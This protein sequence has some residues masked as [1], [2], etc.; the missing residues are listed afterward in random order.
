MR[1]YD[2]DVRLTQ[3]Q[4]DSDVKHFLDLVRE[5][6]FAGFALESSRPLG[7]RF[8]EKDLNIIQRVTLTPRSATR[9]RSL[10]KNQRNQAAL[11]VIHGRTKP[12]WLSAA[13]IPEV[14]MI[15]LQDL[16]DF[17][18]IDS[19]I[20]RA[21]ANNDKPVEICL[22]KLLSNKGPAR[23]RLMRVMKNAIDHLLRAKCNLILTSGTTDYWGLRAP[24]DLAALGYL[25]SIP[26]TEAKNAILQRPLELIKK[27]QTS[28]NSGSSKPH[29]RKD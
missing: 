5:L 12:V 19:Q 22:Q 21:L 13:E 3:R 4:S 10:V 25:A 16:D 27:L 2:L 28:M 18:I 9:L 29:R 14:D 1:T 15:M 20:S 6:E 11:L 17:T 7:Q 24:R 8:H 26:E 23:S